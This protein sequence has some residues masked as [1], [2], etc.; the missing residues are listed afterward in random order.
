MGRQRILED[1][2]S[3]EPGQKIFWLREGDV[4]EISQ[5]EHGIRWEQSD[6][7][8]YIVKVRV[9]HLGNRMAIRD[10]VAALETELAI[11][12]VEEEDE[13]SAGKTAE[14]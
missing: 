7:R 1:L 14:A 9:D 4:V 5:A 10:G 3:A 6:G 2:D 11:G 13:R 12:F 8:V